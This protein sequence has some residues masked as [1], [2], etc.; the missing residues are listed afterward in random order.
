MAIITSSVS[1]EISC[2]IS[3]VMC[4]TGDHVSRTAITD[5]A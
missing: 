5:V 4:L 2:L 1:E 3:Q